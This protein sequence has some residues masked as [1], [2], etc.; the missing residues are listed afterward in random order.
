MTVSVC[1]RL[2]R[3]YPDLRGTDPTIMRGSRAH[4]RRRKATL[5]AFCFVALSTVAAQTGA[6]KPIGSDNGHSQLS[7]GAVSGETN[8]SPTWLS[9]VAFLADMSA[10]VW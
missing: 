4:Q 6:P 1:L 7:D 8:V 5:V 10:F 3:Y 2:V 9:E